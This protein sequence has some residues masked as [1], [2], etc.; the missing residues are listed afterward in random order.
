MHLA[1]SSFRGFAHPPAAMLA[2]LE[3]HGL[4]PTFERRSGIWQVAGLSVLRKSTAP[5]DWNVA[6]PLEPLTE[7]VL[8]PLQVSV[9]SA[10]SMTDMELTAFG[11][12]SACRLAEVDR[13]VR[14]R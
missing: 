2:V 13:W 1:R 7:V 14:S 6:W 4:R 10:A 3:D 9:N 12:R 11:A 5:T 8:K